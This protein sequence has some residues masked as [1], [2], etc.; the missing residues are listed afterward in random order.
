MKKIFIK[1][2][3]EPA[4]SYILN[5][6]SFTLHQDSKI[7]LIFLKKVYQSWII[8]YRVYMINLKDTEHIARVISLLKIV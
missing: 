5:L 1:D 2:H 4:R 3:L 7:Y 6:T 8:Q